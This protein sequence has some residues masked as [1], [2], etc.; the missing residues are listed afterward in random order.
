MN[1]ISALIGGILFG[2]GLAV[3]GMA[4]P[5]KVLA[6]LTL[7]ANWD[8]SLIGVMGSALLVTG[9][10]YG[11]VRRRLRPLWSTEF[12]IPDA[13]EIDRSLVGGAIVFGLGWGLSGYCPGP[14]LVGA[15]LLDIRALSFCGAFL[16]GL[17]G[18]ELL[19]SGVLARTTI[20]AD[21]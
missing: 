6:F 9:I 4:D 12:V 20:R 19:H 7:N 18:Y 15:F 14:G 13:A 5:Q 17:V 2:A 11:L 1:L 21:G 3:S 10:G 16:A 8:P